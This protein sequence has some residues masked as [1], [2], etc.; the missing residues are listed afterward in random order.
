MYRTIVVPV[1]GSSF[2]EFAFPVARTLAASADGSL[3]LVMVQDPVP[4][5]AFGEWV[6]EP[7]EWREEYLENAADRIALAGNGRIGRTLRVGSVPGELEAYVREV[8]P[9]LLVMA[10]HGRGPLSRFWLGSVADYMIRHASCPVLL[11]RPEE[12]EEPDLDRE[13]RFEHVLVPLDGSVRAEAILDHAYE[14]GEPFDARYTLVRVVSLPAEIPSAY[15]PETVQTREELIEEGRKEADRYLARV[16]ERLRE[17]GR[18]VEIDVRLAD[19]PV[20]G[21]LDSVRECGAGLVA[22]ATHGRSGVGRGLLGSVAD[23]LVRTTP[24]PLL[25]HRPDEPTGSRSS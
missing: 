3:E 23:K 14:L 9:D 16:A 13:V 2:A 10:T 18:A 20:S 21:V 25:I 8:E 7:Q 24:V 1:D 15:L 22:L 4:P 6:K 12:D 11:V 5:F 17:A 19:D